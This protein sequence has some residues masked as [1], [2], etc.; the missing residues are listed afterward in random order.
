MA[1]VIID[2]THTYTQVHTYI[3]E[4]PKYINTIDSY[5]ECYLKIFFMHVKYKG[6][7]TVQNLSTFLPRCLLTL[8]YSSLSLCV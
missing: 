6:H 3:H 7:G 4:I 1:A 5:D 8:E 2:V